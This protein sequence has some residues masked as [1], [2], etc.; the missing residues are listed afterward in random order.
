CTDAE[1]RSENGIC[2]NKCVPGYRLVQECTASGQRSTCMPCPSRQ[3]QETINYSTTCRTCSI[4]KTPEND[5]VVLP[6]NKTKD[7]VCRCRDGF[8]K[9]VIDSTKYQCLRCKS[10]ELNEEEIQKCTPEKNTVCACK[11]DYY[12]NN[13][14]CE[15]CTNCTDECESY[16]TARPLSTT[17]KKDGTQSTYNLV[18]GVAAAAVVL[19]LL[20]AFGTHVA[21]KRCT[22]KKF[23]KPSPSAEAP[24]D[25]S[26]E[27]LIPDEESSFDISVQVATISPVCEF[28]QLNKLPDCIPLEIK[29]SDLIYSVLDLVPVSQVKQLVRSLGVRD[30]E[31][32]QVELDNRSCREAH[33]QMLRAWAERGPRTDVLLHPPL[34]QHLLSELR[35]MHLEHAAEE[36]ETN[37]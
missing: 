31:I 34:L 37:Y 13:K 23:Q 33:Y 7:T 36:L 28:G 24:P 2:C 29:I 26:E 22:K 25:P 21:T 4:C 3:F 12:R 6:C 1:Y 15:I 19:L 20:V 32:E 16:C 18:I 11:Q 35:K 8:Y 10:C 27:I 9:S 17:G 14:K 5:D 30:T